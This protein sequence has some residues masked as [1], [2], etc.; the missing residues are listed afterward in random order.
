MIAIG[1]LFRKKKSIVNEEPRINTIRIQQSTYGVGIPLVYGTDRVS[2]NIIQYED[3]TAIQHTDTQK[4]GG[5]GGKKATNTTITYTYTAAMAMS[6]C[7]GQIKSVNKV[8]YD[9]QKST[10][11][12]LGMELFNGASGQSAWPYM[13]SRHPDRAMPYSNT[14]Y[15]AG[16][17]DLGSDAQ[18]KNY[19][20]EVST[21]T[22]PL[23]KPWTP[24]FDNYNAVKFCKGEN[25]LYALF[26][27]RNDGFYGVNTEAKSEIK[28]YNIVDGTFS[29]F[30]SFPD[31]NFESMYYL[32]GRI[33]AYNGTKAYEEYLGVTFD[34]DMTGFSDG[35]MFNIG[36]NIYV[37]SGW[38][39]YRLYN[40]QSEKVADCPTPIS[41]L[42]EANGTIYIFGAWGGF[43]YFTFDGTNVANHTGV[44]GVHYPNG[45]IQYNG[46]IYISS[47]YYGIFKI[48]GSN[49]INY[50]PNSE[51]TGMTIHENT[52]FC[53]KT[54]SD[55]YKY[56]GSDFVKVFN[57]NEPISYSKGNYINSIVSF[58]NILYLS[59][60]GF[61]YLTGYNLWSYNTD[62]DTFKLISRDSSGLDIP[63]Y[64]YFGVFTGWN[65]ALYK[66]DGKIIFK[67]V[68]GQWLPDLKL[69]ISV[70][71]LWSFGN[72]LYIL[73]S[74]GQNLYSWNGSALVFESNFISPVSDI[75]SYNSKIYVITSQY[76]NN[77]ANFLFSKE[78]DGTWMQ[79]A[80]PILTFNVYSGMAQGMAF[81]D[82][83]YIVSG[84]GVLYRFYDGIMYEIGSAGRS[85][86]IFKDQLYISNN[87]GITTSKLIIDDFSIAVA[88]MPNF[89]S[90]AIYNGV[91]FSTDGGAIHTTYAEGDTRVE[92]KYQIPNTTEISLLGLYS[93]KGIMMGYGHNN[94]YNAYGS[95]ALEEEPASEGLDTIPYRVI[96]DIV[97][98]KVKG[99][100]LNEN[101]F[102]PDNLKDYYLYCVENG[103][104]ISI[105]ILESRE[106]REIIKEICMATNSTAFISNGTIKI[107]PF[108]DNLQPVFALN[109]D[110]FVFSSDDPP[111]SIERISTNEAHNSIAIEF[112]N[113]SMDYA[114]DTVEAQDQAS[115]DVFGIFIG[116]IIHL[117]LQLS[118]YYYDLHLNL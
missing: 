99:A 15:L 76:I 2:H 70:S 72:K 34:Y 47:Q 84:N 27:N 102:N 98:N 37:A 33:F 56:N 74:D 109:M 97:T 104:E 77:E 36:D 78:E 101:I 106:C 86:C 30:I 43:S 92:S 53:S 105:A 110:H 28:K 118:I 25:D 115:I 61:S 81:G 54:N 103:F 94:N 89:S 55:I 67:Y 42:C 49:A 46:D 1:F 11:E 80:I 91:L 66:A 24:L 4:I 22:D 50:M 83:L 31:D 44:S 59:E 116:F 5:K 41:C 16:V 63:Y 64:T 100:G 73:S 88:S 51:I 12:A 6:L 21:E 32:N 38:E 69:D 79:V 9:K 13:V 82:S 60:C 95:F 23:F 17:I 96:K 39:I 68:G 29:D 108:L 107:L 18:V 52:L 62:T 111:V 14:A 93:Y 20:F 7:E 10:I 75:V 113:R 19:S 57:P 114:I 48:N 65:N 85:M 90:A 71:R 3:F 35:I 26:Y 45:A 87:G 8:W 112:S 40:G 58:N 117:L